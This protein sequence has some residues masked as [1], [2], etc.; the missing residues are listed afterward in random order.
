M[1]ANA[2]P[3]NETPD[4]T[5][6]LAPMTARLKVAEPAPAEEGLSEA[7]LG[8]NTEKVAAL[9]SGP[10]GLATATLYWVG[11]ISR[12]TGTTAVNVLLLT[13]VV[14]KTMPFRRI[15]DVAKGSPMNTKFA[16]LTVSKV[17]PEPAGTDSGKLEEMT[18][19]STRKGN[20]LELTRLG[21]TT[22][23]RA[24]A[25]AASNAL[26]TNANSWVG[27]TYVVD[28]DVNRLPTLH[29]T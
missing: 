5:K 13:N 18:G 11:E 14:G 29:C 21:C 27:L 8:A 3:S 26:G 6:K 19:A 17:A 10:L 12:P 28:R 25:G 15:V 9:E 4:P 20:A 23:M 7:M 2:V 1:V 16:P 22:V 24:V